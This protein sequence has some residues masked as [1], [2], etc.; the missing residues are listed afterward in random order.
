[1]ASTKPRTRSSD[2]PVALKFLPP[3]LTRD[4]GAKQ[5]FFNEAKAASALC[6]NDIYVVHDNNDTPDG[7]M[8]I[9]VEYL[10][11]SRLKKKIERGPPKIEGT[12]DIEVQVPQGLTK[13]RGHGIAHR[14]IKHSKI[15]DFDVATLAE[16]GKR[17]GRD[18]P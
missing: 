10:E 14:D 3:D 11:R 12:I 9:S 7:R 8:S 16:R 6:H 5:R 17:P 4:P 18:R 15:I 13:A 1:V 2:R